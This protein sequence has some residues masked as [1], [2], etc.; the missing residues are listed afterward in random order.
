[1]YIKQPDCYASVINYI[2][3]ELAGIHCS[4]LLRNTLVD[5]KSGAEKTS[6]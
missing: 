3:P 1:M 4:Q 2:V 5:Q 6:C